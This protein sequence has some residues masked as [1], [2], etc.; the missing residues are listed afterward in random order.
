MKLVNCDRDGPREPPN[1]RG[2]GPEREQRGRPVRCTAEFDAPDPR[3]L[4]VHAY[5]RTS[6]A[7]RTTDG[8]TVI[9]S[10]CALLLLITSRNL[11]GR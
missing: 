9:P 11:S 1:A 4:G 3:D 6:S 5:C 7:R 10:A 8:G 2:H